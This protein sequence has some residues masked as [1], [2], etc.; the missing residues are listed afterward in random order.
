MNLLVEGS[1]LL[2]PNTF[3]PNGDGK[4]ERFII[5]GLDKYQGAKLQVFNRWGSQ[6]YRSNDYRN[7]WNGSGLAE[8]TYY[9]IRK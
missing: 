5:G 9:Y 3:T 2:F 4:N 7:D 1:D 8:S 6:V